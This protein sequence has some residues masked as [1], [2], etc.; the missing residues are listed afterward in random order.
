[1]KVALIGCN[2]E[3]VDCPD[4]NYPAKFT[5]IGGLIICNLSTFVRY[6]NY[7]R[8]IISI[9]GISQIRIR[10]PNHIVPPNCSCALS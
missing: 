10:S 3:V 5:D 1:M 9:Y 2:Q 6:E 8:S 4:N 7:S